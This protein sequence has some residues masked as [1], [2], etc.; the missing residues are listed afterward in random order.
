MGKVVKCKKLKAVF[1]KNE[2]NLR[3]PLRHDF[4]T[5]D[6]LHIQIKQYKEREIIIEAEEEK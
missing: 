5:S 6:G 1:K 4:Y 3:G 2:G